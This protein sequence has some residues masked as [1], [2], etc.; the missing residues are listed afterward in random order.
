M[1]PTLSLSPS[2]IPSS[3]PSVSQAPSSSPSDVPSSSVL[4]T[5]EPSTKPTNSISPTTSP[6]MLPSSFPSLDECKAYGGPNYGN[7]DQIKVM[8][9]FTYGVQS[10]L[11]IDSLLSEKI[12]HIKS[13]LL[14]QL[15]LELFTLCKK[16]VDDDELEN[17]FRGLKRRTM[18][19][20]KSHLYMGN[21]ERSRLSSNSTATPS[22]LSKPL[23]L[24]KRSIATLF[25]MSLSPG[26]LRGS[27]NTPSTQPSENSI[28]EKSSVRSL[29]S[30]IES[31][32]S[33]PSGSPVTM[34]NDKP[35]KTSLL[36]MNRSVSSSPSTSQSPTY[37]N[38]GSIVG[39]SMFPP[40]LANGYKCKP[41]FESNS[42]DVSCLEI[43]GKLNVFVSDT[44][45]ADEARLL[46]LGALKRIMDNGSLDDSHP[47]IV[48]VSFLNDTERPNFKNPPT[49]VTVNPISIGSGKIWATACASLF[50]G[51]FFIGI[52]RYRCYAT[53]REEHGNR[54][55]D[56]E[57]DF[58]DVLE[59]TEWLQKTGQNLLPEETGDKTENAQKDGS[60][61]TGDNHRKR[62]DI[63]AG[64]EGASSSV[65]KSIGSKT[66]EEKKARL[67][68]LEQQYAKHASEESFA[69]AAA[70]RSL[71]E[72]KK[73]KMREIE[74]LYTNLQYSLSRQASV[75]SLGSRKSKVS[76]NE[77]TE[78][79]E[80]TSLQNDTHS[81]SRNDDRKEE[82]EMMGSYSDESRG[83]YEESETLAEF[84][85]VVHR[86]ED[87]VD[88]I[89]DY[90]EI[91]ID[92]KAQVF[93]D[94]E[95]FDDWNEDDNDNHRE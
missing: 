58:V 50:V 93:D 34:N 36:T 63:E 69:I 23:Q 8:I 51:I 84:S 21:Q 88:G 24:T 52:S 29:W 5:L 61:E 78:R 38:D 95:S 17:R 32:S 67:R 27:T 92:D 64:S 33:N 91:W 20:E 43:T 16:P 7:V 76:F 40:D 60:D 66:I 53:F 22:L 41:H 4:P 44:N 9:S 45:D 83:A 90:G 55:E 57:S 70:Q 37:F 28:Y 75:H 13:K 1:Y 48:G 47:S 26:G 82:K 72:A 11:T 87:S 6:S 68:E 54:A 49:N 25:S 30:S 35:F 81:P 85:K 80:V 39:I 15:I 14:D 2:S 86:D 19:Y 42:T 89:G 73:A 10:N 71:D 18:D 79:I 59:F 12:A 74:E 56:N 94:D 77:K 3:L 65:S 62:S 31:S 46:V